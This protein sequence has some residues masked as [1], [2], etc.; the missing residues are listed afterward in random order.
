M[1]L[2]ASQST[3]AATR[4]ILSSDVDINGDVKFT[5]DL[6][7]DGR[8]KGKILSD[9]NLTVGENARL[10]AEIKTG[11]V[12]VYGKVRG[13]IVV[14]GHVELR[15]TAE[16][17]GDIKA[18]TLGIEPGAIFVGCSEVGTPSSSTAPAATTPAKPAAA[19]APQGNKTPAAQPQQGTLIGTKP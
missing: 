4:N 17:I 8:I 10:E 18:K 13:N 11:A 5:N 3:P 9:G 14:T 19:P 6:I 7:I 16:V 15:A 1:S 12:T 2:P